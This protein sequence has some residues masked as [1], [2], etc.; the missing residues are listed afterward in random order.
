MVVSQSP[1][2]FVGVRLASLLLSYSNEHVEIGKQSSLKQK[3][4]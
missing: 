1:K 2:L 3:W 4:E